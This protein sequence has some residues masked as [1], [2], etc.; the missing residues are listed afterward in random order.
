MIDVIDDI[1][2]ILNSTP[3]LKGKVYRRWSK[4]AVKLPAVV[5]SRIAGSPTFTDKDGS[6]VIASLTYSVDINA[7]SQERV[8]ALTEV[9]TDALAEYN[10]HRTGTM[11]FYDDQLQAYRVILTFMVSVDK[12]G[13][14]FTG[15][16]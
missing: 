5:V 14:T 9:V 1:V 4:K 15:G 6:E 2:K 11:D 16:F 3:E 7:S 8:D 12:R 10:M 13:N